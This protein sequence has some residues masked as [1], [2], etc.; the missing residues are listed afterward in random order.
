MFY[1]SRQA[2]DSSG[3]V[4]IDGYSALGA[5]PNTAPLTWHAFNASVTVALDG[6]DLA[7]DGL[8]VTSHHNVVQYGDLRLRCQRGRFPTTTAL[9]S[10]R[11]SR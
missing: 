4:T 3:G 2:Y 9:A 6:R 8:T 5:S 11:W 10:R 7:F 1:Y